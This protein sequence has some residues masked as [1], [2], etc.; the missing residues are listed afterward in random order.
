M[1]ILPKAIY[2]FSTIPIKK[3][4]PKIHMEAQMTSN[5][6]SKSN[7]SPVLELSQFLTPNYTAEP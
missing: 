2:M 1:A 5:R 3:I 4:N 6:Q 7:K